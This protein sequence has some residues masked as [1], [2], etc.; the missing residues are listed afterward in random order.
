MR[1]PL[2]FVVLAAVCGCGPTSG[3]PDAAATADAPRADVG[4]DAGGADTLTFHVLAGG[5]RA[6]AIDAEDCH[7]S[8]VAPG[9]RR[10]ES[11]TS[12]GGIVT[13]AG[14]SWDAGGLLSA[15]FFVPGHAAFSLSGFSRAEYEAALVDGVFEVFLPAR[16]TP[17]EASV[18]V[19]G[20]ATGFSSD[21]MAV[22]YVQ[23]TI[24]GATTSAGLGSVYML[25]VPPA[26]GFGLL[27][28]DLTTVR[29]VDRSLTQPIAHWAL[30]TDVGP[31]T[32]ATSLDIDLVGDALAPTSSSGT[33]VMPDAPFFVDLESEVSVV[34]T[35]LDGEIITGLATSVTVEADGRSVAF[36]IE[37][38]EV[39]GVGD[40]ATVVTITGPLGAASSVL[41]VEP[42][43][44]LDPRLL[45]PP[46]IDEIGSR[47]LYMPVPV[48]GA[49][50]GLET[51]ARIETVGGELVWL[52]VAPDGSTVVTLP[53]LPFDTEET[54]LGPR[55]TPL[56]LEAVLC[57]LEGPTAHDRPCVRTATS[58]HVLVASP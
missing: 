5:S 53:A 42:S 45:T 54:A 21:P 52:V 14:F 31:L 11:D 2:L 17:G 49:V 3:T 30:A 26:T 1:H 24:P 36:E 15:T 46:R 23:P 19:S 48:A 32:S 37:E 33:F 47:S 7:T 41:A 55:G 34:R 4:P 56:Y 40:T 20:T 44:V 9:P 10:L 39:P 16:G 35:G 50:A 6:T 25:A 8:I 43:G 38:V 57:E 18:E 28:T 12:P 51:R 13:L 22:L 29:G 58:P 27:A